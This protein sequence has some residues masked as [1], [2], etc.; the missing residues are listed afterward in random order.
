M[1]RTTTAILTL[2]T[3][4]LSPLAAHAAPI[5]YNVSRTIGTG[6]VV[7]TIVT[8]GTV[9]VLSLAN[10]IDWSFTI[11]SP[12]LAGGSPDVI[13]LATDGM[14]V[15]GSGLSATSSTLVFDFAA[16]GDFAVGFQSSTPPFNGWCLAS[17][18]TLPC[19]GEPTPSEGIYFGMSDTWAE[20]RN[21]TRAEVIAT[22]VGVPEPGTLALFGAGL[23]GLGFMRRRRRTA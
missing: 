10:I 23:L 7:G 22:A 20:L 8:D 14:V 11:S 13:D 21:P 17:A 15:V 18:G 3:V 19:A 4:A 2:L 1:T 5:T 12:N 16:A 9:G 6:S